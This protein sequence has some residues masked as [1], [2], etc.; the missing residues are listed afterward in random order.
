V[1]QE[2]IFYTATVKCRDCDFSI[3]AGATKADA[4]VHAQEMAHRVVFVESTATQH[5]RDED[6]SQ[7]KLS[8]RGE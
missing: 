7:P 4:L 5:I 8:E 1:S 6:S 2:L 3:A